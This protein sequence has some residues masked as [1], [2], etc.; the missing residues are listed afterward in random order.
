MG[1]RPWGHKESGT[2]EQLALNQL[3][4]TLR[5]GYDGKFHVFFTTIKSVLNKMKNVSRSVVSDFFRLHL[6]PTRLLCPRDSLGKNTGVGCHFLLQGILP[7]Q[8]SNSSLLL[9]RRIPYHP[10][11]QGSPLNKI[12]PFNFP[13]GVGWCIDRFEMG[14]WP[15]GA[16]DS[17]SCYNL[18]QQ[19][20]RA[21][22]EKK[23][24]WQNLIFTFI[25]LFILN[26][27]RI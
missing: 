15:Q 8:G 25:L 3:N 7:T 4:C 11:H 26:K 2:T 21:S 20:L 12:N 10:S 27:H 18:I 9:G 14:K 24:L 5:N 23:Q 1:C 17:K 19:T 6:Q 13:E 22:L 16:T